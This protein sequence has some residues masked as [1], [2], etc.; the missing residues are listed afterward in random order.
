MKYMLLLYANESKA[1]QTP[2]EQQAVAPAWYCIPW[3][4]D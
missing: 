2:E 1:P 3:E 4:R